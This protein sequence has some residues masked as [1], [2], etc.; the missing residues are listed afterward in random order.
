M[1]GA[2]AHQEEELMTPVHRALRCTP[3]LHLRYVRHRQRAEDLVQQTLLRAWRNIERIDVLRQLAGVTPPCRRQGGGV[4]SRP[5]S[6]TPQAP[7]AGPTAR[8]SESPRKVSRPSPERRSERADGGGGN[9]CGARGVH[10]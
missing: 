7:T 9:L 3:G 10:A 1:S 4:K 8:P 5:G 6:R 2:T